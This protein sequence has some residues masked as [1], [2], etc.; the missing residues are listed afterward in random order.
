VEVH[1]LST[2]CCGFGGVFAVDQP[3]IST[4]MLRRRIEQIQ[5]VQ[6]DA[7]VACDVSCLMHI[8][9]GLRRIG[10]PIRCSHIAQILAGQEMGLR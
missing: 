1:P 7:V 2:E 9:G 5:A 4:E 3:E 8:E 10:S 6:S